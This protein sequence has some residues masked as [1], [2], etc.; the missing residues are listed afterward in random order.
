MKCQLLFHNRS[1]K[2]THILLNSDGNVCLSGLPYC[3]AM[4]ADQTVA[5]T[6]P[7]HAPQVLP[8]I[9]PEILEQ[10]YRK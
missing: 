3:V 8:W 2:A 9:A 10:V 5:H 1:V 4:S 6:Y 7:D